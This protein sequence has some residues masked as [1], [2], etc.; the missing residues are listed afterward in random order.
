MTT[1]AKIAQ[2][3]NP[4]LQA[5]LDNQNAITEAR[6]AVGMLEGAI[7]NIK[8]EIDEARSRRPSDIGINQELENLRAAVVLGE[9]TADEAKAREGKLASDLLKVTHAAAKVDQEIARLEDT[10]NGL[11]RRMDD[12]QSELRLLNERHPELLRSLFLSEAER[13]GVDYVEAGTKVKESAL[14]IY[15]LNDLLKQ[16]TDSNANLPGWAWR[17]FLLP[18]LNLA[19][20]DGLGA[21]NASARHSWFGV[22]FSSSSDVVG[23]D[24]A[25]ERKKEIERLAAIGVNLQIDGT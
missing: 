23:F 5:V 9:V 4:D 3:N 10:Q 19:A 14:R 16:Y 6:A 25:E 18:K 21:I 24:R 20:C 7:A 11:Q 22:W 17:D 8:R 2:G 12:R 13:I 15:A 1:A